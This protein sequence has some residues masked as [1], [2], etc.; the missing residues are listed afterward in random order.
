MAAPLARGAATASGPYVAACRL[1]Y[2]VQ[3]VILKCMGEQRDDQQPARAARQAEQLAHLKRAYERYLAAKAQA[4]A[5]YEELAA[6][7]RRLNQD[8]GVSLDR[9]AQAVGTYKSR[10]QNWVRPFWRPTGR[11]RGRPSKP[12]ARQ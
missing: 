10:V 6:T 4:D 1:P 9:I 3:P 12:G 5:A 7:A 2:R 8:E 11:P